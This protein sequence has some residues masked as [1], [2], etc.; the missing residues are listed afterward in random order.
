M[1]RFLIATLLAVST[2]SF[3]GAAMADSVVPSSDGSFIKQQTLQYNQ[4][5][6]Q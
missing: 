4:D 3:A 6:G 5:N 2:L 1:K